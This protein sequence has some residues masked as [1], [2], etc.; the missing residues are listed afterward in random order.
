MSKKLL[1]VPVL[2]L[3]ALSPLLYNKTA[4]QEEEMV[5]VMAYPSDIGEMNP[6]FPRSARTGWFLMLIYDELI[7]FDENLEP[8]P[9]LAE[10]WEVDPNGKWIVFHI[11]SGVK[12]HDGQP[13]TAEDVKFTFEYWKNAPED[14]SGWTILQNIESV[15]LVDENTVRINLK[16]PDGFALEHFGTYYIIPKHIWEGYA[17]DDARWDDPKD[18]EAHIGS[19]PFYYVERVPDEYITLRKFED[20]WGKDVYQL[21]NVDVIRIEVIR[22]Q[23]ARILAM[24]EGR[25]A[26][27]RYELW[28][29]DV[30]TVI[31]APETNVITGMVSRWDYVIGFN[32]EIP[33][34]D[35]VRVRR[36]IAYAIDREEI[37]KIARL[38]WGTPTY[39]VIP[40]TFFPLYYSEKGRF[41]DQD[42][43]KANQILDE[44]GYIDVDGDGIREFPGQPDKELRFDMMV[45]SWDDISVDAGAVV[46][47][48]LEKIGIKIDVAITDDAV[49]YPAIYAVPRNFR[50]YEMSHGFSPIPDHVYYRMHSD[51]IIDWGDNCYSFRNETMDEAIEKFMQA[52]S[53]EERKRWAEEIQK[54]AVQNMPYIPLFLSDDTHAIRKEWVNYTMIPGGPFTTYNR[55]TVLYIYNEEMMPAVTPTPSP[56]P[57]VAPAPRIN[58]VLVGGLVI[59]ALI[60]GLALGTLI[61]R[62]K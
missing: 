31:E 1:L 34:L 22:G 26:T 15:E 8:V 27:E 60:I 11:R 43:D 12:W 45:L 6:L 39:S 18:K 21:P 20:W 23:A 13:L 17:P 41:P 57:T 50:I 19:G 35:D 55:F 29:T 10:S 44:A 42:L 38:G 30:N 48:Q 53:I 5:F 54:I 24:R 4:A 58:W 33:G 14:A 36:A 61:V 37:V 16:E 32:L 49:M 47:E 40:E 3:I 46:A 52:T 28:G 25:A 51:N 9:W 7:A 56:T 59:I 2:I 62:R